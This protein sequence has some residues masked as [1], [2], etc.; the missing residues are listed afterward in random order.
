MQRDPTSQNP[1]NQNQRSN[2]CV[3]QMSN[4]SV[5][6]VPSPAAVVVVDGIHIKMLIYIYNDN[7]TVTANAD[8]KNTVLPVVVAV[9][10]VAIAH[11]DASQKVVV[12]VANA[13][14]GAA[15][16]DGS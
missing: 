14:A 7:N 10:A 4:C 12:F 9:A 2:W 3:L 1:I 11:V 6:R 16:I 5:V 15:E 13:V 8:D